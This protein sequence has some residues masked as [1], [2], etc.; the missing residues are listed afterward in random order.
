VLKHATATG[1]DVDLPA[2]EKVKV[3]LGQ[4]GMWPGTFPPCHGQEVPVFHASLGWE[5]RAHLAV[6]GLLFGNSRGSVLSDVA[7]AKPLKAAKLEACLNGFRSSLR[8]WLA[9]TTDA[10]HEVTKAILAHV[11]DNAVVRPNRTTEFLEQRRILMERWAD[12]VAE[13]RGK[14][15]KLAETGSGSLT[16]SP[17]RGP[18]SP[19]RR[20]SRASRCVWRIF[21]RRK[22][23][24]ER[25]PRTA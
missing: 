15:L 9:E 24:S 1:L 16:T 12:P 17:H 19:W 20:S 10:P 3:L 8:N 5:A 25:R 18:P 13:D 4:P 6:G 2:T 22:Q 11:T 14:L 21:R 23:G 7:L